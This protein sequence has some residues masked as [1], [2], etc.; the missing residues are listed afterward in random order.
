MKTERNA[1]IIKELQRK[2]NTVYGCPMWELTIEDMDG[3]TYTA[4]TAYNASFNF[5]LGYGAKGKTFLLEYHYTKNGSMIIDYDHSAKLLAR[6]MRGGWRERY[7]MRYGKAVEIG[8]GLV[9]YIY[10]KREPIQTANGATY[11]TTR[12]AWVN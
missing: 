10:S 8:G 6:F 5:F 7:A 1:F 9:K 3:N 4:K 12:G 11:D 2:N